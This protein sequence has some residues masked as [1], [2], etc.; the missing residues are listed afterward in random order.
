MTQAS[1]AIPMTPDAAPPPAP[2]RPT[3]PFYWSVRRELW[4]H[5]AIYLAPLAAAGVMI[6]GFLIS[7]IGLP[8]RRVETL[9]L[10]LVKQA[11]LVGQPYLFAA[12][13]IILTMVIVG[14]FYCLSALNT[15]RR[16]RTILFW[17]SLPVSDL[18]TVLAKVVVPLAIL[19]VLAFVVVLAE[20]GII[21][22]VTTA[23]LLA[24]GVSP[25]VPWTAGDV[26]GEVVVLI[27]ALV[28]L[29]LWLAPVYAW[30]LLVSAWAR[31][32]PFLWAVLPPLA[33][34]FLEHVAFNTSHLWGELL[35]RLF[36]SYP[37]AFITPT[38]AVLKA[39]GGMPDFDLAHLDPGKFVGTPGLYGGL[40][41][42]VVFMAT[43]IWLRR[44]R[45]P[46]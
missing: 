38:K 13:A 23:M 35:N 2:A 32:A 39:N 24:S 45:E 3:R 25:A 26:L 19:P 30:L 28:T 27:Y 31:R 34:C 15:E 18:V 42:G 11:H 1:D 21:W 46:I 44:R 29:T 8:Q 41:V 5:A 16:D 10:D 36:G 40:A 14:C 9:K 7:A 4:E 20:Q 12:L 22:L 43:A 17:K 6:V 37:G 33:L